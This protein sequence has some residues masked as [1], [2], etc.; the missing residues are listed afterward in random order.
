[1]ALGLSTGNGEG[2]SFLPLIKFDARS[3]RLTLVEKNANGVDWDETD[4]TRQQPVMAVDFGSIEV[5]WLQ[6]SKPPVFLLVPLGDP[7]PAKPDGDFKQGFRLKLAGKA[8]SGVR[9]LST[10]SKTVITAIDKL[11]SAFERAPEAAEGKIPVVKF[12]DSEAA[13][14]KT[15]QGTLT[16]YAPVFEVVQWVDRNADMLGPRTVP[17]PVKQVRQAAPAGGAPLPAKGA[18]IEEDAIPF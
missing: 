11:H 2:G 14:I 17:P 16:F 4:I 3:G 1:M 6:Y 8:L 10:T 7:M 9:E 13:K 12:V 18:T 15:P 5:G